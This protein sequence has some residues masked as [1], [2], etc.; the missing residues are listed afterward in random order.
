MLFGFKCAVQ[1][2]NLRPSR[3]KLVALP[4]ELTAHIFI[5]TIFECRGG[6]SVTHNFLLEI[7]ATPPHSP[8]LIPAFESLMFRLITR[9]ARV[10]AAGET[11]TPN[12]LRELAPEASV[13]TN[14]TTTAMCICSPCASRVPLQYGLNPFYQELLNEISRH[15]SQGSLAL[16]IHAIP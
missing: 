5:L 15:R 16:C 10:C 12:P 13:S 14:F 8:S 9:Q 1:D 7:C 3:C 2:S 6:D 11:R 4:A